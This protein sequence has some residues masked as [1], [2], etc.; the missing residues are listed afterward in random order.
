MARSRPRWSWI[1]VTALVLAGLTAGIMGRWRS[2]RLAE[3][4]ASR[5][6]RALDEMSRHYYNIKFCM[7]ELKSA[8]RPSDKARYEGLMKSS[9]HRLVKLEEAASRHEHLA[10]DYG[11]E[12]PFKRPD[13]D[14]ALDQ[15]PPPPP[16]PRW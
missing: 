14:P 12:A 1:A 3:D 7:R 13:A 5:A 11:Y 6:Q 4:H 8:R 2:H 10:R 15:A 16:A 9:R